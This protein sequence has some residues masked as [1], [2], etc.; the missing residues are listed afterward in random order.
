MKSMP[1]IVTWSPLARL[2]VA[3]QQY[4]A[5]SRYLGEMQ[6]RA[7]VLEEFGA[8]LAFQ[9]VDLAEPTRGRGSGCASSPA[10]SATPTSTPLP[11]PIP[12]ATRRRFSV[13]EGAGV[14]ERVGADVTSLAEGDHVVTTVLTP[15]RPSASTASIR[16]TNLCMAIRAE[17]NLGHLPD[18]SVRLSRGD[19]EIRH[20]MGCST[21]AEYTVMPEDRAGQ[22]QPGGALRARLPLRLRALDRP[23]R[24]AINTAAVSAGSTC[25][26]FGAGMVGL[27]AVAGLAACRAP[28]G[29]SASTSHRSGWSSL[30]AR[31]QPTCSRAA[32]TRSR[33]S[34]R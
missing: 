31:A 6:I 4:P 25:V 12:P 2:S 26:V 17:Q 16:G 14:V 5:R 24:G 18:G 10:A 20:F 21:F 13:S 9:E 29:S 23:R 34:L 8:P 15:V 19:E 3:S 32:R 30:A 7:A 33:R 22:G 1:V 27:G 11:A 28:S